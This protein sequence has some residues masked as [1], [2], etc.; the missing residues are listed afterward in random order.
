ME[1]EN[2]PVQKTDNGSKTLGPV[3]DLERHL[4]PRLVEANLQFDVLKNRCRCGG[5]SR[6][7]EKE[8]TLFHKIL[9]IKDG[10]A[11][12]DLACGQGRHLI[13]LAQRGNYNLFGLDRCSLSDSTSP[14][15]RKEK[16]IVHYL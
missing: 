15:D 8:V 5:R 12:L 1:K 2:N 11:L 10:D 16:G 13:E 6:I 14:E 9:G 3:K 7:T 4:P